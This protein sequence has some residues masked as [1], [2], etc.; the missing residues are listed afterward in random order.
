MNGMQAVGE[1]RL[2]PYPRQRVAFIRQ[3][4]M[5][6]A[7]TEDQTSGTVRQYMHLLSSA[8]AIR[9]HRI[10]AA[11]T[12]IVTGRGCCFWF[13]D[14]FPPSVYACLYCLYAFL[15]TRLF[16]LALAR[17]VSEFILARLSF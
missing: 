8:A 3:Y 14:R 12:K 9:Q 15:V 6:V 11:S 10:N 1:I 16:G 2:E 7:S 4:G 5:S 17:G 13:V